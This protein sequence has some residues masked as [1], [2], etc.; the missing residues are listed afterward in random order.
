MTMEEYSVNSENSNRERIIE[1]LA[2]L[3]SKSQEE[4]LNAIRLLGEFGDLTAL[5]DLRKR[6]DPANQELQCLIVAIG[7]LKRCLK[8]K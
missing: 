4:R 6:L 5:I 7:K 1:L 2:M 8:V 3:D